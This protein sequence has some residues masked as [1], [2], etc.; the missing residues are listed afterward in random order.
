MWQSSLCW[1]W[2]L[3]NIP[4]QPLHSQVCVREL[5]VLSL[6]HPLFDTQSDVRWRTTRR[7]YLFWIHRGGRRKEKMDK[8]KGNQ[9]IPFAWALRNIIGPN[10][11]LFSFIKS[12]TAGLDKREWK[13]CR[14]QDAAKTLT[15]S[16]PYWSQ[17]L[18]QLANFDKWHN[19]YHY[20]S[21]NFI[22]ACHI[23]GPL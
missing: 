14:V 5:A 21:G 11:H 19:D 8:H 2:L 1:H 6:P 16:S 4:V 18:S 20:R 10:H 7:R 17:M 13:I 22:S 23:V 9:Q 3:S 12:L 15:D